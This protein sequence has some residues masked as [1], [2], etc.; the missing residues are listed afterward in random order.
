M[1]ALLA[2]RSSSRLGLLIAQEYNVRVSV[3]P[4]HRQLFAIKR[5]VEVADAL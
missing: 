5:P 4:N 3:A 2:F 1:A